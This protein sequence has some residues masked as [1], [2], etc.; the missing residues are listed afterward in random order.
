MEIALWS[1]AEE[2]RVKVWL[3]SVSWLMYLTFEP[4]RSTEHCACCLLYSKSAIPHSFPVTLW[5]LLRHGHLRRVHRSERG[6]RRR[7]LQLERLALQPPGGDPH[8][9]AGGRSVHAT[10]GEKRPAPNPVRTRPVQPCHLPCGPQ[11]A[12]VRPSACVSL[13]SLCRTLS[14]RDAN[15]S[16]SSDYYVYFFSGSLFNSETIFSIETVWRFCFK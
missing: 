3:F 7:P 16:V 5:P 9:G 15:L 1:V 6:A 14:L 11:P 10:A 12:L 13:T 4:R 2:K 8:G